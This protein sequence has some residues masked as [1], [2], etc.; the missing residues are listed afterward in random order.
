MREKVHLSLQRVAGEHGMLEELLMMTRDKIGTLRPN[1]ESS[2][3]GGDIRHGS[4]SPS[5]ALPANSPSRSFP[6]PRESMYNSPSR[7]FIP[8][9]DTLFGTPQRYGNIGNESHPPLNSS[10]F[11]SREQTMSSVLREYISDKR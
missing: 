9:R 6:I 5:K 11:N 7:D 10:P 4:R 2:S 1:E 3:Q 8:E